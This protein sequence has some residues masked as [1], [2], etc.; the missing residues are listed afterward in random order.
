[1]KIYVDWI[2][3]FAIGFGV[4]RHFENRK[5]FAYINIAIVEFALYI[6]EKEAKR[7]EGVMVEYHEEE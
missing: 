4:V 2:N 1:M 5:L 6:P 7:L 3:G